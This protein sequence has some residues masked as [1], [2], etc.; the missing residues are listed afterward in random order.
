MDTSDYTLSW[1]CKSG[2]HIIVLYMEVDMSVYLN[3]CFS[4]VSMYKGLSCGLSEPSYISWNLYRLVNCCK[5][6]ILWNSMANYFL[7]SIRALTVLQVL[8]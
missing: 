5:C 6:L 2:L 1:L 7:L 4:A 8:V 3:V